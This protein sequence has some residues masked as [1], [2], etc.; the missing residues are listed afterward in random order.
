MDTML[1]S[2]PSPVVLKEKIHPSQL[3]TILDYFP[4]IKVLSLDC[5]DTL[6]WRKTATPIDVFYDLQNH[7]VFKEM[8]FTAI[9]RVRAEVE[10]RKLK[11]LQQGSNEVQLHDIYQASFPTLNNEQLTQLAD[12][13][14][15]AEINAC[16]ALPQALQLI[17]KAKEKGLKIIITSDTYLK[18]SELRQLLTNTLPDSIYHSLDMVFCSSEFGKSKAMGLFDIILKKTQHQPHEIL[19][20]G[21]NSVADFIAPRSAKLHALHFIHYNDAIDE[22]CRM[23]NNAMSLMDSSVRH[24]R[25]ITHVFQGVLATDYIEHNRPEK[26]IG[27]AALGPIMYSFGRF[28]CEELDALKQLGKKVKAVFLMRDAYLPSLICETLSGSSV[29]KNLNISRFSSYAATFLSAADIDSYLI[30]VVASNRFIDIARQLLLPND[31]AKPIIATT[32]KSQNPTQEFC[33]Q[34]R[35]K[36]ILDIILKESRAYRDRLINY[37]IKETDIKAG[38]TLVLIDLG[39]SGTTQ[40]LLGKILEKELNIEV[41]G[42]YLISLAV[43]NWQS[44]RRGLLDPSWCDTR[45]MHMLVE[46]IALLEQICTSN[47]ASVIDYDK[48]GNPIF[49]ESVLNKQQHTSITN[50]QKEIINFT[51]HAKQFFSLTSITPSRK[52]LE[53]TVLSG[54][55]R[56]LFFPTQL[57]I[58]HLEKFYFDLSLATHDTFKLLDC[59]QGLQG[60]RR[61]GPFSLFNEKNAKTLRTNTP[62]ELRAAGLELT[63]GLIN[64]SRFSLDLLV[65]DMSLRKEALTIIIM[66]GQE[67]IQTTLDAIPTHDGFF[68]LLIPIGP[69]NI[70]IGILF[71]KKYHWLQ[72]ESTEMISAKSH[73]TALETQETSDASSYLVFKDMEEKGIDNGG[74]LY[75]C[76]SD[77]SFLMLTPTVQTQNYILRIVFRPI[78][79]RV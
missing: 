37:I 20:I 25:S 26:M 16:F 71:G 76:I 42:R 18:E 72:I 4:H 6:L 39:Y 31:I 58:N 22:L 55:V 13:E 2:I 43:P 69:G 32:L 60:L 15:A 10:A 45:S 8:G 38:D 74:K 28:I 30:S 29:G 14:I 63:F 41:T 23:Q 24:L 3:A 62:H 36:D 77:I 11:I 48:M 68:S 49:S 17:I 21:D 70:S 57:E 34:V 40:N 78:T 12:A 50:I 51:N 35:K 59:E 65:K 61:R 1:S 19:H 66:Q 53:D 7:F 46:Y 64:R 73:M 47:T 44:S 52:E 79:Y 5:F 9:M 67:N 56:L 54:L 33:R 75:E 27:Y